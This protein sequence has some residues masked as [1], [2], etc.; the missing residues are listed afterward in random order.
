VAIAE[1]TDVEAAYNAAQTEWRAVEREE[2]ELAS[3]SFDRVEMIARRAQLEERRGRAATVLLDAR[4]ARR[5]SLR[6]RA[7]ERLGAAVP[8]WEA[9]AVGAVEKRLAF[10]REYG[11][12]VASAWA[13]LDAVAEERNAAAR[14][15]ETASM[16]SED[17]L[18]RQVRSAVIVG[19]V[20]ARLDNSGVCEW[21]ERPEIGLFESPGE[22]NDPRG[23]LFWTEMGRIARAQP[24][25]ALAMLGA[26]VSGVIRDAIE[27]ESS[28]G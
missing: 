9:A 8:T 2:V 17:E 15:G 3:L 22:A 4:N 24:Q 18:G 6:E 1:V 25:R 14:L 12:F 16:A 21:R 10:E 27:E 11:R 20:P 28:D 26:A 13:Y 19:Q 23:E 7:N 5:D